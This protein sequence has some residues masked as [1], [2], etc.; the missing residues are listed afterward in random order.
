MKNNRTRSPR[1]TLGL[2]TATAMIASTAALAVG[3]QAASAQT[4]IF[5]CARPGTA[6]VADPATGGTGAGVSVNFLGFAQVNSVL[7]CSSAIVQLDDPT[8]IQ[9]TS[10]SSYT[11][12]LIN[13]TG[14]QIN[15]SSVGLT[16]APD[17]I[18]VGASV[19]T[20]TFTAGEPG[21]YLY[22]STLDPRHTLVG[23]HGVIVVNPTT[24]GT[25]HGT[26]V[27]AYDLE[28]VVVI[29]E[30]DVSFN[31]DP[32]WQ[33]ADM[34]LREPDLFLIN[35]Q[36]HTADDSLAPVV[37]VPGERLLIRYVNAGSSNSSM[38]VNGLRQ[39]LVA[40]DGEIHHGTAGVLA[41][42]PQDVSQ[43]FLSAGQTADSIVVVGGAAGDQIPIFNRNLRTS[44]VG[45]N[46]AQLLMIEVG[47]GG[48]APAA[49]IYFSLNSAARNMNGTVIRD[50]D[51]ALW[52]GTTVS[53]AFVGADHGLVDGAGELADVDAAYV[54]PGGNI[55]FS[56]RQD[57]PNPGGGE[58]TL[59][60]DVTLQEN[61]IF[62][63]DGTQM[64][65]W[66]DGSAIGLNDNQNRHDI[67]G[68]HVD[69][70]T[71]ITS[72]TT[73]GSVNPSDAVP[74]ATGSTIMLGARN[75]DVLSWVP[76][77]AA[78]PSGV[79]SF[80]VLFD[81]SDLGLAFE[82]IDGLSLSGTD[83]LF[84]LT[85]E[86]NNGFAFDRDDLIGCLGHQLPV[87]GSIADTCIGAL[88]LEF[89]A[90]VL[91]A[92]NAGQVDAYSIG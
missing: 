35:G 24:A 88:S 29:S 40:F 2:L 43:V 36:T 90:D 23:L 73:N 89:D 58:W 61:D 52:D 12:H 21:T 13:E 26:T 68:V 27:S 16:G 69:E 84:S 28:Q 37:A 53:Y 48:V 9:L 14:E 20:Y 79:G 70:L 33:T 57:F 1:R 72:F 50:E 25:A 49:A 44:A 78:L 4:D 17:L 30:V 86:F 45:D 75:E 38:A 56:L 59:V 19:K 54:S 41:E 65:V 77:F 47:T 64:S 15:F 71:G 11:V 81:G 63:W 74:M 62:K 8:P 87:P 18:G 46:G 67:N 55:Y 85:T 91:H 80:E 51:I 83:V 42:M 7:D 31:N 60:P 3:T 66:L 10:G 6:T 76:A 39:H 22:E 34:T 92:T 82:N 5:L 32:G